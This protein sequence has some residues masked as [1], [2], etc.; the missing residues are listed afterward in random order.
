[1]LTHLDWRPVI[2]LKIVRSPFGGWGG[3]S[4]KR[5]YLA[6]ADGQLLLADWTLEAAERARNL[7]CPTGW[8]L[9]ELPKSSFR[10]TGRGRTVLP[11]GTWIVSY[12]DAVF[13][14]YQDAGAAFARL[15]AEIDRRPTNPAL[16]SALQHLIQLL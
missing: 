5:A 11:S 14:L 7:V 8:A 2:L 10:L 9:H 13:T 3:L 16:L 4:V 12:T 15:T 6:V 1:M